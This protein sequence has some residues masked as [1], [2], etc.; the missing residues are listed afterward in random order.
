MGATTAEKTGATVAA[1]ETSAPSIWGGDWNHAL[2]GREW[3]GAVAGR[4]LLL[5][6]VERLELHVPTASSPH[7]IE[8]LLSIDHIAVPKAWSV[9]TTR[10]HRAFAGEHRISDH[11]AYLVDS[12]A[13]AVV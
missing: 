10:R 1:V 3:T 8:D 9:S 12:S 4:R 2:S 13:P 5:A 7:Q 11:D 6:A